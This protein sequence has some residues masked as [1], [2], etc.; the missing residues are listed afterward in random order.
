MATHHVRLHVEFST[1]AI[2]LIL[3]KFQIVEPFFFF[4]LNSHEKIR[5]GLELIEV[6]VSQE[7]GLKACTTMPSFTINF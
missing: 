5:T 6:S 3:R 7:L 2:T 4:F 1:S